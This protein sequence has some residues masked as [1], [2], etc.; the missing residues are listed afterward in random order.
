MSNSKFKI[1]VIANPTLFEIR[2]MLEVVGQ[3]HDLAQILPT[4]ENGTYADFLFG[5]WCYLWYDSETLAPLGYVLFSF[6]RNIFKHRVSA[7]EIFFAATR[8]CGVRHILK[9]R[10]VMQNFMASA[11]K[12]QVFAYIDSE[13]IAKLASANGFKPIKGKRFL[14]AKGHR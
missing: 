14:W 4:V 11:F 12:N 8:F 9:V 13:R 1:T 3:T 5:G 7:P 6:H 10:R 2:E